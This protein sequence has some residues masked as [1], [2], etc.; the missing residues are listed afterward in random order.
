MTK[1]RN[2]SIPR[3]AGLTILS[4]SK[5]KPVCVIRNWNFEIVWDLVLEDWCFCIHIANILVPFCIQF[6]SQATKRC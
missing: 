3:F 4:L 2:G 6:H 1:I 5:D